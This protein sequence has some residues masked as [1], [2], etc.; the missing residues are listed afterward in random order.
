MNTEPVDLLRK[1]IMN[2][3]YELQEIV[4]IL[5]AL[6]EDSVNDVDRES[7]IYFLETLEYYKKTT[8]KLRIIL[9]A[10]FAEEQKAGLP[11]EMS[12]RR[13]YKRIKD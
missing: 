12:F 11:A 6:D 13:V 7:K 8:N 3:L 5:E 1:D 2:H 10:Y 4:P 9:E